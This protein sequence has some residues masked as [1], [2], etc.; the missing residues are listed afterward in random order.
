MTQYVTYTSDKRKLPALLLCLL[1]FCGV[2]GLH[3]IYVGKVCTGLI[4]LLTGGFFG[5]GTIVD[6]IFILLGLFRDNV[7]APLLK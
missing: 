1:G 2:G 5:I 3:R 4:W 7:G 6:L